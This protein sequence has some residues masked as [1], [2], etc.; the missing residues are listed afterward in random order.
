MR[1]AAVRR[2]VGRLIHPLLAAASRLLPRAPGLAPPVTRRAFLARIPRAGAI[3]EIGPY[4]EPQIAGAGV[5]YADIIDQAGL[6]VLATA[7]GL[8]AARCPPIDFVTPAGDLSGIDRRFDTVFSSHVIEHQPD[9]VRHLQQVA[10]LLAPGGAY[11][12][13]IPDKRYC[14]DHFLA[15]SGIDE[16]AAAAAEGRRFHTEAA[17]RDQWL[18]TTHN[19]AW[20]HWLGIHGARPVRDDARAAG[21]A[22]AA[23]QSRAG[24]YVDA[25]ARRFT[26][27]GFRTVIDELRRRGLI[28]LTAETVHATAIGQGE[29]FAVLRRG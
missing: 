7:H 24:V 19:D 3:L 14:F 20:R 17:I 21:A 11:F 23:A 22:A 18:A 27:R 13:T 26:P 5:A 4:T 28:A 10:R 9:L 12:L 6:K 15:E 16:I 1:F 29:F 2:R 25:H 8:D